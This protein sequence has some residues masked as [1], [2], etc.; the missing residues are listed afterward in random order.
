VTAKQKIFGTGGAR[1]L[2]LSDGGG[3]E[4]RR[5]ASKGGVE[6]SKSVKGEEDQIRSG[7]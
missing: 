4:T 5:S 7:G 6:H 1:G 3:R 2:E